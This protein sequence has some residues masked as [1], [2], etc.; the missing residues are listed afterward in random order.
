MT[1]SQ[2][3]QDAPNPSNS[4][5]QALPG[6]FVVRASIAVL[7]GTLLL[8]LAG[9]L[10]L[11][12]L[13]LYLN[14]LGAQGAGIAWVA[15]G[16][17]ATELVLAPVFGALSDRYGR[18]IFL[19]LAPLLGA[20]ALVLYPLA[21]TVTIL[22]AIRV[23]EGVSA[24]AAIPA[25]LG[26]LSDLTD[27]SKYRS[28]IMGLFEVMTL[29]GVAIGGTVLG[30][31][32]WDAFGTGSFAALAVLYVL[33]A[34][35]FALFLPQIGLRVQR[36]RTWA[37]YTRALSNRRILRF[38]PAWFAAT[39]VIG[40]WLVH[41]QSQLYQG[42]PGFPATPVPGQNLVASLDGPGISLFLGSFA[43]AFLAGLFFG[44]R[45]NAGRKST[46]MLQAGGGLMTIAVCLFLL[47]HPEL[48]LDWRV[49]LPFVGEARGWFLVLLVGAFFQASFTPV[50]LAYLADI[51]QDFPEDRGVVVGLYSIFLAGGN[52]IGGSLLGGPFVQA[53][54]M[55]G[56]ALLTGLFT[57]VA[58]ASVI[59]IRRTS[60]D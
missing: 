42:K 22:F 46:V 6:D 54:H 44:S 47:N 13:G 18:K 49:P 32:V 23:L 15:A 33:G 60:S 59:N 50:A 55:D 52:L 30:P 16:Y 51:S 24:G 2:S 11:S 28:R 26:Y 35:V 9:G 1:T 12:S 37:D 19:V 27:G 36:R 45:P 56:V 17:Y 48:G 34:V 41:V 43:L 10:A 25:T 38:M 14:S 5:P 3:P 31:R 7:A 57:L 40:L 53:L 4:N 39:G 8:R 21:S 29:V 58:F 20:V